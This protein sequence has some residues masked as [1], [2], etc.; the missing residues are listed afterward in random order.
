M[1]APRVILVTAI[2][3][4]P[5]DALLA[6][7]Q[8]VAGLPREARARLAVQL[9]DPELT[10]RELFVWGAR[11]AQAARDV[12]A[13]LI[14]NDRIDLALALGADGCH[15]G[16][17]SVAVS[18]ARSLL[19]GG[20][21]ISVAC[22]SIEDVLQAAEAGA[23]AAIL[24]P[25]FGSPGKGAP[26]GLEA[27]AAA[28]RALDRARGALPAAD[29]GPRGCALLALGG[30]DAARAPACLSAGADGVALVRADLGGVLPD[31]LARSR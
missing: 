31:L 7:L 2:D 13:G 15:L 10:G 3:E 27:L 26:L 28:R 21:F 12:G 23:D 22:H 25:V 19:G 20:A 9:R 6:R 8:A 30:I 24:S 18:D 11:L 14:V 4:V 1:I 5:A 16:R 29:H 17:R